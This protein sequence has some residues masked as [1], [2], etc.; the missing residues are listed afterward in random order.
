MYL[1]MKATF[2]LVTSLHPVEGMPH[3]QKLVLPILHVHA[4]CNSPSFTTGFFFSKLF[5]QGTHLQNSQRMSRQKLST[6]HSRD[7]SSTCPRLLMSRIIIIASEAHVRCFT[8]I[9]DATENSSCKYSVPASPVFRIWGRGETGLTAVKSLQE[10]VAKD[11][12]ALRSE[13]SKVSAVFPPQSG[14]Q[15]L[16]YWSQIGP[17]KRNRAISK[18]KSELTG[19]FP[20]AF[21]HPGT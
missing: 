21:P 15:W 10:V 17:Q 9:N 11:S 4:L 20:P 2:V 3:F 1:Q 6:V 18:S 8:K 13:L 12:R 16:C 14:G 7:S 19:A 5:A